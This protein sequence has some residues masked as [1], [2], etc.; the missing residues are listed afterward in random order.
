MKTPFQLWNLSAEMKIRIFAQPTLREK[1]NLWSR[2]PGQFTIQIPS[3]YRLVAP[4][5][6]VGQ[7]HARTRMHRRA[8]HPAEM[9]IA[10]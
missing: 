7:A 3:K 4:A 5:E 9:E 10:R 8:G 2:E 1:M 6:P